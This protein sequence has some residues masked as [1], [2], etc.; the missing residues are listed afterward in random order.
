LRHL[1]D[2]YVPSQFVEIPDNQLTP[3]HLLAHY[4]TYNINL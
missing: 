4:S 3:L 2:F 1:N